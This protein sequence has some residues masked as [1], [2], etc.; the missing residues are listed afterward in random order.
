[1][2]IV[3]A[4]ELGHAV[5]GYRD[6]DPASIED[7]LRNPRGENVDKIENRLRA[8]AG[9]PLRI[10]YDVQKYN[11]ARRIQQLRESGVIK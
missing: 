11:A 4:H 5:F 9:L 6:P 10:A 7:L 3:M 2:F 8:E 1:M